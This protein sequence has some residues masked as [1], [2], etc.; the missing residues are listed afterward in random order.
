VFLAM[1][2]KNYFYYLAKF[3]NFQR[4]YLGYKLFPEQLSK[5]TID[6][7]TYVEWIDSKILPLGKIHLS[8]SSICNA[9][10]IFCP[11]ENVSKKETFIKSTMNMEVFEQICQQLLHLSNINQV[12]FSSTLG[13]P[14]I[15]STIFEKI[16]MLK[17]IPHI[18]RIYMYS[19][20]ILLG[21]GEMAQK[22]ALSGLN[23]YNISIASFDKENWS[24]LYKSKE[25]D[26]LIKGISLLLDALN[27]NNSSLK[28]RFNFRPNLSPM[29]IFFQPQLQRIIKKV[30]NRK[31]IKFSYLYS[32]LDWSGQIDFEKLPQGF[33]MQPKYKEQSWL[34]K[35]LYDIVILHDGSVRLCGC[36]VKESE[37]DDLVIGNIL[38][39]NLAEIIHSPKAQQIRKE[40]LDG[41]FRPICQQCSFY[42]PYMGPKG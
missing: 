3:A 14:L 25:F 39:E 33:K 4:Y 22:L 13:E 27:H 15:D 32:F 34:C 42:E 1:N 18:G 21:K 24:L 37:H 31:S 6:R 9:K 38:H 35:K 36:N 11:Y 7:S 26:S 40:F 8:V 20:G 10:C 17:K 41:I 16:S 19:N 5:P 23:E 28:V 30:K 29:K 2:L 12:T